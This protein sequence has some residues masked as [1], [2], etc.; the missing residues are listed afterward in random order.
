[1]NINHH[2]K[3]PCQHSNFTNGI[4]IEL[5]GLLFVKISK[6]DKMLMKMKMLSSLS[7][8]EANCLVFK[9]GRS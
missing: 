7:A 9:R 2:Y 4:M 1:M 6:I 5:A 3:V 8:M